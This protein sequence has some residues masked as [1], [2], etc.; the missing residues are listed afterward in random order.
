MTAPRNPIIDSL[1]D[2][3]KGILSSHPIEF[4]Y[5]FGSVAT[6]REA[7]WSDID[8]VVSWPAFTTMTPKEQYESLGKLAL[9]LEET[10][11]S[12][13]IDLKVWQMVPIRMQF[14]I[15]RDGILLADQNPEARHKA[16][17]EVLLKY[18]DHMIWFNHYLAEA[19][20]HGRL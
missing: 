8:F 19:K 4:A 15:L 1:K 10:T 20:D 6:G 11:G 14:Q 16:K 2:C 18:P 3:A 17:E 7:W 13:D 5:L 12:Q 9:E